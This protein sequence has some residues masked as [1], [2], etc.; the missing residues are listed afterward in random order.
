MKDLIKS[1]LVAAIIGA[2]ASVLVLSLV[3][4]QSDSTVAVNDDELGRSTQFSQVKAGDEI[5]FSKRLT[6]GTGEQFISFRNTTGA[7]L[8]LSL[9]N[10]RISKFESTATSSS[11]VMFMGTSSASTLTG[12]EGLSVMEGGGLYA[13]GTHKGAGVEP[14]LVGENLPFS[15]ILSN[16][17][18]S[19]STMENSFASSTALSEH[20]FGGDSRDATSTSMVQIN[21]LD[22]VWWLLV[23]GDVEDPAKSPCSA[24]I[25]GDVTNSCESATSTDR[26]ANFEAVLNFTATS[27][28]RN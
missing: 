3:G 20:Q 6:L 19:T 25:T 28:L 9:S 1:A 18:F 27:T 4:K 8:F 21:N 17:I 24:S 10:S 14:A 15:G 11:F 13:S 26:G 22:Y 7:P 5:R 16:L 12:G 23:T 2:L